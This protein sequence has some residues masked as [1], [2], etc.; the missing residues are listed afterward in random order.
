MVATVVFFG[1]RALRVDRAAELAAPDD[2]R[3][4]QHTALLQILNQ[5]G[6][7]LVRLQALAANLLRQIAVLIPT[8][9]EEL[10]EAHAALGQ[11]ARQNAVGR[12]GSRLA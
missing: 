11:A 1:Q 4:V 5:R 3:V 12:V 9:M 10:D 6:R 2:Q 8:A 7:W